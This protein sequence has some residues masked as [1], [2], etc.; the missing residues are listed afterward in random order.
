V[1]SLQKTNPE[2]HDRMDELV[3]GKAG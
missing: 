3:N 2:A 1:L